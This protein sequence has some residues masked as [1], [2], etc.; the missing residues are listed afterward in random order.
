MYIG[1]NVLYL[2]GAYTDHELHQ[3]HFKIFNTKKGVHQNQ[4]YE[5]L[6]V[7]KPLIAC[8]ECMTMLQ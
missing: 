6:K 7:F 4:D 2:T 8:R 3:P 5:I 1:V